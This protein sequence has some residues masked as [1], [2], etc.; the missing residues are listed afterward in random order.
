MEY[1][2]EVRSNGVVGKALKADWLIRDTSTAAREASHM[3]LLLVMLAI[4]RQPKSRGNVVS[5]ALPKETPRTESPARRSAHSCET[6][7]KPSMHH[8]VVI[9]SRRDDWP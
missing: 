4:G 1:H 7:I 6:M 2:T 8:R 9:A 3:V 5:P